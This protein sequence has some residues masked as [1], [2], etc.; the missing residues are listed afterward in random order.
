M[1]LREVLLL[2][3]DLVGLLREGNMRKI[4]TVRQ[5]RQDMRDL[6]ALGKKE[7]PMINFEQVN[8]NREC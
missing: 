1:R 7:E 3:F 5:I 2:Y 8:R 4:P 6:R